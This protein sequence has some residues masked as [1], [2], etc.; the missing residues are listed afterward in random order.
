M[1][2]T[3]QHQIA[4]SRLLKRRH[5]LAGAGAAMLLSAC[6]GGSSTGSGSKPSAASSSGPAKPVT[7]GTITVGLM[8]DI[9]NLDPLPSSSV[10]DRRVQYQMFEALVATDK[11]L[12]LLP[13]LAKS[14]ET[15]DPTTVV[16]KL[17]PGVKFHD[18]TDFNAEAVKFNFDR[19]LQS[20]SSPRKTELTGLTSLEAVDPATVKLTLKSPFSPLLAQLVDRAGMILSPAAVTKLG[21][22]LTRNPV[23][24]GT[25]PFKFVEYKKDDHIGLTRNEN[26]WVKDQ[27][28]AALP[29]IDKLVFRPIVDGTQ[30][31]N[32]LKT[33]EID[34]ADEVDYKDIE[35]I[36]K[37]PSLTY[38]QIPALAYS[39]FYVN[40]ANEI[41]R[42]IRVRQAL[43]WSVD[44]Q[45]IVEAVYYKVPTLAS[46]PIAPPHFAY[47]AAYKPFVRDVA[48]AKALLAAA[49]KSSVAFTMQITAGSLQTQ[50]LAELIKDQVKDAG[51]VANLQA[52]DFPT[53]LA[54]ETKH[55]FQTAVTG[56][57]GRLDPDGN[58][59]NQLHTGG[60]SNYGQYSNPTMDKALE[61]ARATYDQEKRKTL[62]QQIN[63]LAAEE[64]PY[65]Y[66]FYAV[67]GQ[68]STAKLKNFVP[69]PDAIYR[70]A[71]VWK[72]A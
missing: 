67:T 21:E 19:I 58:T 59:Y 54:N 31:F 57:S 13:G 24:A 7:G 10:Y 23:G 9:S 4:G 70:F 29:Y 1:N 25:G 72:Q 20:A 52:I 33:G 49:G 6:G 63:K 32:S 3:G 43:A 62:Y 38:V 11:D 48:K 64:V 12:K 27:S 17:Q 2:M 15:P 18:G 46:G 36:K 53:I 71:T 41:F 56:W 44:R 22:G 68:Y 37:E 65:V 5:L 40:S 34:F 50:Q 14:W 61:D 45:K 30:R 8:N 16:F 26:Y 39:G 28:G 51:F 55:D 60:G 42:D 69:V 35:G 66:V 47:D